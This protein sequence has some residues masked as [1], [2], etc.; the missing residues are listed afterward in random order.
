MNQEAFYKIVEMIK[1]S[2][3]SKVYYKDYVYTDCYCN[4]RSFYFAHTQGGPNQGIY[5]RFELDKPQEIYD[6][7]KDAIKVEC[8]IGNMYTPV[9]TKEH[10]ILK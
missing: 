1:N 8:Y 6:F 9:W 2:P 7:M 3:S 10:G 5:E 4:T